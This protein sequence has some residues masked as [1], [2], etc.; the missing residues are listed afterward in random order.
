MPLAPYLLAVALFAAPSGP[1][2]G[3]RKASPRRRARPDAG[4]VVRPPT[5]DAGAQAAGEAACVDRWLADHRLDPYG[6]PEGTMYAGGTPLFDER[7][8]ETTDRLTF[9][10]RRHP[11]AKAACHPR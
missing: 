5:S 6:S 10:Y 9:V 4:Q 11:D 7:T 8:G 2:G 3:T 1:D